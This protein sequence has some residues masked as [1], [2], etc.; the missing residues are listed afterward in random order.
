MWAL[1]KA[2]SYLVQ[3][4]YLWLFH[5]THSKFVFINL[6]NVAPRPT[7]PRPGP[8]TRGLNWVLNNLLGPNQGQPASRR[9]RPQGDG[10]EGFLSRQP[11]RVTPVVYDEPTTANPVRSTRPPRTTG[12]PQAQASQEL[13]NVL[14]VI[15]WIH[16]LILYEGRL[17][18]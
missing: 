12:R 9:P 1:L 10:E 6:Q 14:K 18:G 8:L 17:F 5:K 3:L 15:L 4:P 11:T 2:G 16:S 13:S 7:T